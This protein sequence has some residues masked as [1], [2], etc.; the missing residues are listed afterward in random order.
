MKIISFFIKLHQANEII[1]NVH[2]TRI[3]YIRAHR[4]SSPIKMCMFVSVLGFEIVTGRYKEAN[5]E[6]N[7]SQFH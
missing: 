1:R 2:A 5:I 6:E 4:D 7:D 3:Q